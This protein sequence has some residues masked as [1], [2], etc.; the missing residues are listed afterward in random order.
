M[1]DTPDEMN[2][3]LKL[4]HF[5]PDAEEMSMRMLTFGGGAPKLLIELIDGEAADEITV[6]ITSDLPVPNE[7]LLSA[8]KDTAELLQKL[9]ESPQTTSSVFAALSPEETR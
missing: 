7:E 8:L 6:Q 5:S 4:E 3:T 9:V 2:V 1:T